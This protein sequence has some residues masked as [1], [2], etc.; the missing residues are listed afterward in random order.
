MAVLTYLDRQ[1]PLDRELVLGRHRG[2]GI[3]IEDGKASRRH[4]RVFRD[5]AGKWWAEDL[6]SA[7]GTVLNGRRFKGRVPLAHQDWLGIGSSRVLISLE[8]SSARPAAEALVPKPA[9]PTPGLAPRPGMV[10]TEAV[11]VL[12]EQPAEPAVADAPAPEVAAVPATVPAAKST[13]PETEAVALLPDPALA[14]SMVSG[15]APPAPAPAVALVAKPAAK[16]SAPETEAMALPAKPALP[17]TEAH[18]LA[19]AP[20]RAAAK[21]AAEP[22]AVRERAR[23]AGPVDKPAASPRTRRGK[24]KSMDHL[25]GS[26]I[27]GCRLSAVLGNGRLGTVFRARQIALDREVAIKVFHPKRAVAGVSERFL[28]EARTA[29]QV[30]HEGIVQVHECGQ[31][32]DRLWYSMELVEGE[33]LGRLIK[34]E[35][36]LSLETALLVAERCALALQAAHA[37]GLVHGDVRPG[38]IM[39]STSG[40]IKLLDLG[41]AALLRPAEDEDEPDNPF[42]TSPFHASPER[43]QGAPSDLRSDVYSLGCTLYHLLAGGPPFTGETAEEIA[44]AHAKAPVPD[45]RSLRPEL[46]AKI[47][48]CLHQMMNKNPSWRFADMGEVIGELRALRESALKSRSAAVARGDSDDDDTDAERP[49]VVI[50]GGRG[51]WW[52]MFLV[53]ALAVAVVV[54]VLGQAP[55]WLRDLSAM[56]DAKPPRDER[57]LPPVVADPPIA[58]V[59]PP[60]T[61][62]VV[63]RADPATAAR[64][65][66]SE[67]QAAVERDQASNDW[68][69]G[70]RR[71]RDFLPRAGDSDVERNVRLAQAKLLLDGGLWYRKQ[72][73]AL[74]KTDDPAA[75]STRLS[76]LARLRDV[77]LSNDRADAEARYQEASALLT[78]RLTVARR[79]ARQLLVDGKSAE[80]PALATGLKP[81]FVN[82]PLAGAQR[83]FQA[84]CTEA[85]AVARLWPG[86]WAAAQG[87]LRKASGL[88]AL[89][90]GAALILSDDVDGGKRLLLAEPALAA[91]P[92]LKRRE[93][94]LGHAVAVLS[95][96]DPGDITMI[97][98]QQGGA[99]LADGSLTANPGEAVALDCTVPLGGSDWEAALVLHLADARGADGKPISDGQA[100]I[101]VQHGDDIELLVRIERSACLIKVHAGAGWQQ[102]APE[103]PKTAPLRL[104]V[105]CRAGRVQVLFNDQ[106]VFATDQCRVPA[107]SRLRLAVAGMTWKLDDLLVVGGQ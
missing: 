6:E 18:P 22:A 106:A 24:P 81:A 19:P 13:M 70:E 91:G 101:S 27:G 100:V 15:T 73:D 7:N 96:D 17:E 79:S 67:V 10:E 78:Q 58:I 82:T 28:R 72:R 35:G 31:E 9:V 53:A 103:R 69:A 65:R 3:R 102:Q 61:P 26:L 68:G 47:D 88:D 25:V 45:V 36:R 66:W 98:A 71:L 92:G 4:V 51:A 94:V 16:S 63:P 59:A 49:R 43:G 32:G 83:Q 8:E 41:L 90:A 104:R 12:P 56:F 95:F 75:L 5:E 105:Q 107:D 14:T 57:P 20:P 99:R 50:S 93:A 64:S 46:P 40:K 85:A 60:V 2:C 1:Y 29:G 48:A 80:L 23:A 21:S 86:T 34:R 89:A 37:R 55:R 44:R 52:L 39:L 77:A 33:T 84:Q 38:N 87:T 30:Q 11:P 54:G 62:L 97:D 42:D 76:G 74:P